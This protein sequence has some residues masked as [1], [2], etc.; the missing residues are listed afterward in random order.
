MSKL[1]ASAARSLSLRP[2]TRADFEQWLPLWQGYQRFYSVE[3][4]PEATQLTFERF[5]DGKEPMHCALAVDG[6]GVIGFVHYIE[7]RSS[8]T[9]GDYCYLQDLYVDERA[10]GLGAGRMLIE[11]VYTHAQ[12]QGCARVYWLTQENNATARALYDK[13]ADNPGFIQYRKVL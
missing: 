2:L 1:T 6:Q 7:H 5:L 9:A 4:T 13:V 10:R 3:L 11:H 8:W 12:A